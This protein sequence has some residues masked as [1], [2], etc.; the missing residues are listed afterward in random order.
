SAHLT[1]TPAAHRPRNKGQIHSDAGERTTNDPT[2]LL[3]VTRGVQ[4]F[5]TEDGCGSRQEYRLSSVEDVYAI[6]C[7]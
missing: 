1:K 3:C 2:Q 4:V 5:G 6:A 7:C